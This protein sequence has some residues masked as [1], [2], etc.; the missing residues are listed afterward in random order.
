MYTPFIFLSILFCCFFFKL[1]FAGIQLALSFC[2]TNNHFE[3]EDMLIFQ[4]SC[5]ALDHS[6]VCL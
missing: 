4:D 5:N 1:E 2:L 3:L 6:V